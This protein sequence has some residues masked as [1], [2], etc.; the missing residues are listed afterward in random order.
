[1]LL[2]LLLYFGTMFLSKTVKGKPSTSLAIDWNTMMITPLQGSTTLLGIFVMASCVIY[3][4]V[5]SAN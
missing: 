1:M 4:K 5:N 3:I 2:V